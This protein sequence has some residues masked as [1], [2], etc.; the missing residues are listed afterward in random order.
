MSAGSQAEADRATA[1]SPANVV[2]VLWHPRINQILTGSSD[3][4]IHVLYSPHSSIRG[5]TLALSR[6]P[7]K[8]RPEEEGSTD[9]DRPIFTPHALPMFKDNADGE[10]ILA[11]G[12]GGKRKRERERQDPQKT[13]KPMPPLTGP[14]RGGRVGASATQHVVK[15]LVKDSIRNEDVRDL[16]F[17]LSRRSC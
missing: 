4:S 13:M 12:R 16:F 17:F 11:S 14:G 1:I 3:G 6:Q 10:G 2:R 15:G 9:V 8:V 5:A 7:R